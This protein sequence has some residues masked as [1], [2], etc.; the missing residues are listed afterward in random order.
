VFK[1]SGLYVCASKTETMFRS[2]LFVIA[3]L[4]SAQAF[5][6]KSTLSGR[7]F[8]SSEKRSLPY[9]TLSLVQAKDSTLVTFSRADS[10]GNFKFNNV[11]PGNYLVSTSF[12]GYITVW[13]PVTVAAGENKNMGVLNLIDVKFADAVTVTAKRP[14]VTINNDT[15]EFN[16]ENFKTQP[17]AVVEDMLKKMPGVTIDA[18]GTVRVNGQV[19]R[20]VTVNGKEFFTGDPKMATKN[21]NADAV[22]KVQVYDRK[23]DQAQFTGVDDG[24]TE[25]TI[26]LKLKK[27]R[28]N[29]L[30]GK[31]T[32][33]GGNE[34]RYDGQT[35]INQFKGDKQLSVLGMGN[36]TNKQGFSLSDVLNFTGEMSRGMRNG[37]GV[38]IRTGGSDDNGLPVAGL[39][40]NQQGIAKTFA[41][42]ANYNNTWNKRKTDLNASYTTSDVDLF[43]ER[44][45]NI[46]NLFPGNN[47]EQISKSTSQ[48][49]NKQNRVNAAWDQKIDSFT[50]FKMTPVLQFQETQS[51]SVNSIVSRRADRSLINTGNATSVVKS[52][53]IN[54]TNNLLF[55]KRFAKKGRTISANLNLTYNH[56]ESKGDLNSQYTYYTTTPA[57]DSVLNQK[58]ERDAITRGFGASVTYTEPIGKRSL[59]ELSGFYNSNNG[60]SDRKTYDFNGTS[61]K[62]DN[63]NT[64]L[65]NNFESNYTYQGG[66]LNF[67]SNL[68]KLNLNFGASL[69]DA[70]LKGQ[71]HTFKNE[72]SQRFTDVLP[73]MSAQYSF[74]RTKNLRAEYR[75]S[76]TQPSIQQLQPV[77]D[78]SDPLNIYKGNP[79]LKRQYDQTF[80]MNFFMASMERRTNLFAFIN[81]TKSDNAIVTADSLKLNGVR[82]SQ[83]V[84]ASGVQNLFAALN[85]G[86]PIRALKSN[87]SFGTNTSMFKNVSFLNGDRNEITNWSFGPNVNWNF[88]IDNKIELQATARY[89]YSNVKYSLQPKS[90]NSFW[91]QTYSADMTNFLP[92]GFVLNN[93]LNYVVNTGRADGFNTSVPLWNASLAKSFFKN[94]RAELKLSAFD[95]LDRNVGITRSANQNYIS[96]V[97]YNVLQRYF[98]ASVTYSLNKSGLGGGPRAVIRTF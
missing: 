50:S 93:Q 22:D 97:K 43:T 57:Y 3:V 44:E 49:R 5:S 82:T 16:T 37:G 77:P 73:N 32:A 15:L 98:M 6:Q 53:A 88:S 20:K 12:V 17:N 70:T 68:S 28:D 47:Y 74:S 65:T 64:L 63:A 55:R 4:L 2:L 35:N 18:D 71:N 60:E 59:V 1:L 36:N 54:F 40:Q 45:S 95:L 42:G 14:P 86:F 46:Q 38:T 27:D 62:Y 96:D 34:G 29:S 51:S 8:D 21:L 24:N 66:S 80:S 91:T 11:D 13:K 87:I 41:G 56:S 58:N 19:V 81:Y 7:V 90:N 9:A 76:T 30:F 31:V 25:K 84:N 75:T 39:G 23:S 26:N 79:N 78:V 85:Y 61:G 94:K 69:Q 48:R 10:S 89:N 33:G 83:P 92:F 72:I 67:R 52:N